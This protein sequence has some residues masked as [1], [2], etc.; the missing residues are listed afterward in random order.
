[1]HRNEKGAN[2]LER[3]KDERR[4]I[5]CETLCVIL[6]REAVCCRLFLLSFSVS[7]MAITRIS[8]QYVRT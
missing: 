4:Q 8:E 6:L 5:I 7:F 1:M 2:V 3:I